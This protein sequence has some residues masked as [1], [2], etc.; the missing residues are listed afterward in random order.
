VNATVP[1]FSPWA[2]QYAHSRP[3]YP[4]EL[5][6]FLAGLC[7]RREL[8]WDCATGNGQAALG[9]TR[10]FARVIAT[11]ASAEQIRHARPDPRIDY[12]VAT[13]ESSGLTDH[14]ADLVTVAAAVH[15]F[16][17][18]AFASELARVARAGAVLAVWTYHVGIVAPPFGELFDRLYWGKLKPYFAPQTRQVDER[19]L[20]LELPGEPVATPELSVEVEWPMARLLAFVDSWSGSQEYQRATGRVPSAEIAA[21]LEAIWG[22]PATIRRL[23]WPLFLRVQKL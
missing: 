11:D 8:A 9:L 20:G 21:E 17:P 19:Y 2:D 7:V 6:E 12:R 14:S 3:R 16:E 23:S 22:D 10:H 4:D 1:D 5:F 18:S 13:A 15:W